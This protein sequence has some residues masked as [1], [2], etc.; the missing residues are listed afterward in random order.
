MGAIEARWE[1]EAPCWEGPSL[2]LL[3]VLLQ[4]STQQAL[5]DCD[6][7]EELKGK[8]EEQLDTSG[9]RGFLWLILRN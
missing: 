8:V 4:V 6:L 5:S 2:L 1:E 9:T 3:N 7:Q